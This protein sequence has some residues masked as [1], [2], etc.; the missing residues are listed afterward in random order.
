MQNSE[1]EPHSNTQLSCILLSDHNVRVVDLNYSPIHKH[2]VVWSIV[3]GVHL[4]QFK[5]LVIQQFLLDGIILN[6]LVFHLVLQL[7]NV[8]RCTLR[9]AYQMPMTVPISLFRVL[10]HQETLIQRVLVFGHKG[11]L[12]WLFLLQL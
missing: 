6:K 7:K 11:T 12:L 4:I 1:F 3:E 2:L 8:L 10:C 5:E 9:L